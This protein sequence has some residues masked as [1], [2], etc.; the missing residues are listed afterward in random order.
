MILK[1][2]AVVIITAVCALVLKSYKP[3]FVSVCLCVGGV[4]VLLFSFDYLAQSV[5]VIK[6]FLSD[7]A[8]DNEIIRLL[9]KIVGVAYV[10]EI[11]SQS[12]NDLGFSGLNDK[13]ILCGRL[14]IFLMSVP[15]IRATFD[16]IINLIGMVG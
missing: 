2:C 14:I 11:T 6:Q 9:L 15:V 12:I 3:E 5:A 16:V 13:L 8:I 1:I 7:T 4:L 10:I